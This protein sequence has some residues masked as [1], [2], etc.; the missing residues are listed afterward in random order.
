MGG[1]TEIG[2]ASRL[3]FLFDNGYFIGCRGNKCHI[4]IVLTYDGMKEAHFCWAKIGL[5]WS[6]LNYGSSLKKS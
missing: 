6:Y 4:G 5:E 1:G 2:D 3:D